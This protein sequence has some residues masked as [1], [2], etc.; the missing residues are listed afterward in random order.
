[1]IPFQTKARELKGLVKPLQSKM[2]I[3]AHPVG[4]RLQDHLAT[5]IHNTAWRSAMTH[6]KKTIR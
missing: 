6:D 3:A 2:H 5:L 4:H 1:M